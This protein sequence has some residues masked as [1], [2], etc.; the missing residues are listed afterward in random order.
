MSWI[1]HLPPLLKKEMRASLIKLLL[2]WK[3][4]HVRAQNPCR[5]RHQQIVLLFAA[6]ALMQR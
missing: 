4:A 2:A 1:N 3:Q 6:R 5:R